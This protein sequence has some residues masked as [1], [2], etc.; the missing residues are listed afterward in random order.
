MPYAAKRI[1]AHSGCSRLT[2]SAY[3]AEHGGSTAG[4]YERYAR[5]PSAA[6]RYG[7]DWRR[8]RAEYLSAHPLCDICAAGGRTVPAALVHHR[9]PLTNSGTHDWDNLQALCLA[10]HSRLHASEGGHWG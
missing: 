9:K 1:C 3:C 7:S 2:N 8:V 5:D 6:A 4:H 10:C